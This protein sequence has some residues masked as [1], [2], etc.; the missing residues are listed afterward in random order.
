MLLLQ[1]QA[2]LISCLAG[3]FSFVLAW[4]TKKIEGRSKGKGS[5]RTE[6]MVRR[7]LMSLRDEIQ[8]SGSQP[9]MGDGGAK[10]MKGRKGK[11]KLTGHSGFSEYVL[12]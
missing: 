12:F 11:K 7:A 8:E 9:G 2:L 1:V 4:I 10:R 3:C 5:D 6:A